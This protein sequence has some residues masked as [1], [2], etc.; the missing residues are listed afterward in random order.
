MEWF[1]KL[2]LPLQ[3][4]IIGCAIGLVVAGIGGIKQVHAKK[5]NEERREAALKASE[6]AVARANARLAEI[7]V[8]YADV[9]TQYDTKVDECDA[10]VSGSDGW[11]EKKTKCNREK[12]ELQT[13]MF[14]LQAEETMLKSAD[15]TGY[16]SEVKPMTYI[17]FYIVG[18]SL[19]GVALLAAFII[20]LVKGKKTY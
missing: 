2:K 3:I 11:F 13:K 19:A 5:T 4:I 1:K 6:E 9:K 8:E 17:V 10:V 12:T 7:A 18:A 16:Y 15:Y 14:N 20:Y